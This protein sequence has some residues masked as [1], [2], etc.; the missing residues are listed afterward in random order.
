MLFLPIAFL[1][2]AY[3]DLFLGDL[4]EFYLS[5]LALFL[6]FSGARC[7]LVSSCFADLHAALSTTVCLHGAFGWVLE[8]AQTVQGGYGR[9]RRRNLSMF[10][11]GR[12]DDTPPFLGSMFSFSGVLYLARLF[13]PLFVAVSLLQKN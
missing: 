6:L 11:F 1:V 2:G 12:C 4:P 7:L 10:T 8:E 3:S 13:L 9:F 5:S